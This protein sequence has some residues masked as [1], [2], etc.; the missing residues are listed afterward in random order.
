MRILAAG[1]PG[2]SL[3]GPLWF[4]LALFHNL[5]LNDL[6]LSLLLVSV[7]PLV[8]YGCHC[9]CLP[10]NFTSI[11]F[12]YMIGF[13]LSSSW[14]WVWACVLFWPRKGEWTLLLCTSFTR[15]CLICHTHFS[16]T[17]LVV[18]EANVQ[19]ELLSAWVPE[20]LKW[21]NPPINPMEVNQ[22]KKYTFIAIKIIGLLLKHNL[23]HPNWSSWYIPSHHP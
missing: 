20:A 22:S 14:G 19:T 8:L 6:F 21:M 13:I 5:S 12:G 3:H 17:W 23:D 11:P 18:T 16:L 4:Y 1:T 10:N 7:H 15:H 2:K 9:C